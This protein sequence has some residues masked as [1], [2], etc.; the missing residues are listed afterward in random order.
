MDATD[1]EDLLGVSGRN[2]GDSLSA[3]LMNCRA[4]NGEPP[5]DDPDLSERGLAPLGVDKANE[6]TNGNF[7][8]GVF[9]GT[10]WPWEDEASIVC[11]AWASVVEL[12]HFSSWIFTRDGES[13]INRNA[14][15]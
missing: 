14:S 6:G 9:G 11:I 15:A 7:G 5:G 3:R 2:P 8:S 10:G 4:V 13:G 1:L 12:I